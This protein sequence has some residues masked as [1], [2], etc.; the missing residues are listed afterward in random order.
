[1]EMIVARMR[2]DLKQLDNFA[3]ASLYVRTKRI[4]DS[5]HECQDVRKSRGPE[6]HATAVLHLGI[7]EE[8][9]DARGE[10][11]LFVQT[12]RAQSRFAHAIAPSR[13]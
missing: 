1:M 13:N 6:Y 4:V 11:V 3:L 9:I 7:I 10:E 12:S 8:E 2:D 5:L